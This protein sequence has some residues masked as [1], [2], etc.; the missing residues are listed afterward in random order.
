R[1]NRVSLR[2]PAGRR[3]N[4][5][6]LCGPCEPAGRERSRSSSANVQAFCGFKLLIC[7][8]QKRNAQLGACKVERSFVTKRPHVATLYQR[9][10]QFVWSRLFCILEATPSLDK[11]S[12]NPIQSFKTVA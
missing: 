5:L 4:A 6:A 10:F 7:P 12:I 2:F 1:V 9:M 8:S 11:S 3:R